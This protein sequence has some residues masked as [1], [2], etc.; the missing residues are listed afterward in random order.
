MVRRL[1]ALMAL[2]GLG[3]LVVTLLRR[4]AA[5]PL[6]Q[7]GTAAGESGVRAAAQT[8]EE[9]VSRPTHLPES[10][11]VVPPPTGGSP[12]D[13]ETVTPPHGDPLK[14]EVADGGGEAPGRD[15]GRP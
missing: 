10:E 14:P 6:Y 5:Q 15:T 12:P 9:E 8:I 13:G 2:L 1:L 3:W 7:W 4:R 11:D